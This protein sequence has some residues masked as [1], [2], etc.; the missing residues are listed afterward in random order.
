MAGTGTARGRAKDAVAA[1]AAILDAAEAAF[2]DHGFAGARIDA[3]AEASGYNKSLIFHYFDDKLGL[4][5]AVIQRARQQSAAMQAR[6]FASLADDTLIT[7]EAFRAF[8]ERAVEESFD[9]YLTHPRLLRIFAWE[10]A[11]GWTTF[12]KISSRLDQSHLQRFAA[13]VDRAQRAGVLRKD[14]SVGFILAVIANTCRTYLDFLPA[15]QELVP[16]EVAFS[17]GTLARDREQITRFIVHGLVAD[18]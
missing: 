6:I 5:T 8:L 14:I 9:Y 1:Q 13:I 18:P 2:A 12:K 4:Y 17:L 15:F 10:E 16:S 3:I 11:E 7:A